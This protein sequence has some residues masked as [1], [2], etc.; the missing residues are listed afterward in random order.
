[1]IEID[2][3]IHDDSKARD[4]AR[5]ERLEAMGPTVLRFTNDQVTTNPESVLQTI[6]TNARRKSHSPLSV[7]GEGSRGGE[8]ARAP[9][10]PI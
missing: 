6:Q 2:G 3:P 5:T 8:V 1:M 7:F 9:A 4:A 10:C